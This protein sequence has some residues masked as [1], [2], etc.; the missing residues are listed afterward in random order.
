MKADGGGFNFVS[1]SWWAKQQ[2]HEMPAFTCTY[3]EQH[4]KTSVWHY[5][6]TGHQTPI[7]MGKSGVGDT[8]QM[9]SRMWVGVQPLGR[10]C[11]LYTLLFPPAIVW[12]FTNLCVLLWDML[13]L[14]LY[15]HFFNICTVYRTVTAALLPFIDGDWCGIWNTFCWLSSLSAWHNSNAGRTGW[16]EYPHCHYWYLPWKPGVVSPSDQCSYMW[17]SWIWLSAA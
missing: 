5:S 13:F 16:D 1:S 2:G 7:K 15:R 11:F 9:C 6:S 12:V 17:W 8:E 14:P 4:V 3:R 10:P